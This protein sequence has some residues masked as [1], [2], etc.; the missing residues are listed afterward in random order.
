M[1][2]I[3]FLMSVDKNKRINKKK[4]K[5]KDMIKLNWKVI[6][7][8]VYADTTT[9]TGLHARV[10]EVQRSR[11]GSPLYSVYIIG[12]ERYSCTRASIEKVEQIL[13]TR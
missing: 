10:V 9:K 13:E 8:Y 3:V 5:V 6:G 4:G 2:L 11:K 12:D 7:G 1:D